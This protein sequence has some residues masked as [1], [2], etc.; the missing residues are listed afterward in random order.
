MSGDFIL[1]I[2]LLVLVVA[3]GISLFTRK[4]SGIGGHPRDGD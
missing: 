3:V 4:G 1:I 2:V